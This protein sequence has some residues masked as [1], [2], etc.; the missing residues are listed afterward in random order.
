MH[1]YLISTILLIS[2]ILFYFHIAEKYR[3]VDKPT[4]RSSHTLVTI[5]GGGVIFPVAAFLWFFFSGFDLPLLILGVFLISA[6][7]FID[8]LK[9]LS[10]LLRISIHLAA[11]TLLFWQVDLFRLHWPYLFAAYMLAIG[12]INAFNFMDGINAITPFYALVSLATFLYVN[13]SV[14][15]APDGLIITVILSALVFTW[16]N[17]RKR[18]RCFAGDVGSIS[19][20][21]I[22]AFLMTALMNKTN[23]VVYMMFFAVYGIDTVITILYRINYK[24]NIFLPHRTHLYQYLANEMKWP[25]LIVSGMYAGLQLFVNIVTLY[26]LNNNLLN[27]PTF[28][29]FLALLTLVYLGVRIWVKRLIR[30]NSLAQR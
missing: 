23:M 11:V 18:A 20:A 10:F 26:L 19:I 6:V 29:G 5:R 3:I 15:F 21:F 12:W 30:K 27:R 1:I 16:F 8:D 14:H 25:H 22:L 28:I 24:E 4:D 17:A 13:Q 9:P 7:S 2:A